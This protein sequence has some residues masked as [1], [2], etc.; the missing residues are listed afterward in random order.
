MNEL[1]HRTAFVVSV[2]VIMN[3]CDIV[4]KRAVFNIVVCPTK[5]VVTCGY[6]AYLDARTIDVITSPGNI[7]E[8]G[9]VGLVN[10]A[11]TIN[12]PWHFGCR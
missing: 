4:R 6:N 8:Q 11:G 12:A 3:D 1:C 9:N 2:V 5:I 7:S 10:I